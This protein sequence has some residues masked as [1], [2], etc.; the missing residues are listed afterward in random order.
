MQK[1]YEPQS[2]LSTKNYQQ[3]SSMPPL[4]QSQRT[5][6]YPMI[7]GIL[8]SIAGIIGLIYG[9]YITTNVDFFT[10]MIDISYLQSLDP[11]ITIET[12]KDTIVICGTILSIISIFPILGGILSLKRKLWGVVLAC[13]IIGLF[14][15]GYIF[16]SS[17]LCLIALVLIAVSKR[18]F[19]AV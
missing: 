11:N 13:S 14:S 4:Q 16:T 8:L 12:M 9:V 15:I 7:G 3:E 10:S 2:N 19:I 17:I 5:S 1:D 6:S 18:E